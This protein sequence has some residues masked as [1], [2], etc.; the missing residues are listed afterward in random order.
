[1]RHDG[2]FFS[3]PLESVDYTV[4]L[5]FFFSDYYI[6]YTKR[7]N[8]EPPAQRGSYGC[9]GRASRP[10]IALS[11]MTTARRD[12]EPTGPPSGGKSTMLSRA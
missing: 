12:D 1:M 9:A 10:G 7:S 3:G 8:E 11:E 4:K 2:S 5:Q 6:V